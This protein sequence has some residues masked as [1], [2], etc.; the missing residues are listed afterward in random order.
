M[1]RF[2][3]DARSD[4]DPNKVRQN[5]KATGDL[6]QTKNSGHQDFHDCTVVS[7]GPKRLRLKFTV[8]VK[9]QRQEERQEVNP[10]TN[11]K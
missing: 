6:R 1:A 7:V 10:H 3:A 11:R 5:Q 4:E 9:K 8:R 2:Q